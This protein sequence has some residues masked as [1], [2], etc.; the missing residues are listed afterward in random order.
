MT[1]KTL[2]SCA[3]RNEKIKD[4]KNSRIVRLHRMNNK[5]INLFLKKTKKIT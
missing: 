4:N 3:I 1:S 5:K 2:K